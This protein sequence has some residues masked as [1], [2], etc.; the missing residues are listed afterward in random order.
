MHYLCSVQITI[1]GE[2]IVLLPE[3]AVYWPARKTLLVADPHF[4]K[5]THFNKTGV[6]VPPN[7]VDADLFKLTTLLTN[8]SV[9]RMVFLGDLFHST[10]NSEWDKFG[11]WITAQQCKEVHLIK[12]NHDIL[13]P[14]FYSQYN[15][16]VHHETMV[17][18][19]F[20]YVHEYETGMEQ[21]FDGQYIFSGHV[22]PGVYVTGKARQG[23]RV[24]CFYFGEAHAILPAFGR[25]TGLYLLER[26]RP[27]DNFYVIAGSEIIQI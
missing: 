2:E 18:G 3:R 7:V 20:A 14:E 19:P 1:N 10:Y 22:H 25:F 26:E 23:A 27:N 16:Q 5:A 24:P 4:G 15:L 6:W 11:R 8:L 21:A 17:D 12:G 13:K 9:E